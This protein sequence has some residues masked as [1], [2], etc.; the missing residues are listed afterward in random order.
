MTYKLSDVYLIFK[1]NKDNKQFAKLS[2]PAQLKILFSQ[3]EGLSWK[4]FESS[5]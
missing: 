1:S 5:G 3:C 2:S 4:G